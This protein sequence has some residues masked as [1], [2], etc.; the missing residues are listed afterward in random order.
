MESLKKIKINRPLLKEIRYTNEYAKHMKD[1]VANKPRTKEEEVRM[2][3]RLNFNN[4]LADLGA[5][6]SSMPL[7]MYKRLGI[8]KLEQIN[9][10]IEMAN[11]TKCTPKGL[12]ENL[13]VKIDKLIFLVDFVILDIVEDIRMPIILGRPLLATAHAKVDIFRK[14]IS[15]EVG[16]EKVIFKKRS[17]FDPMIFE[18][19][20]VIQSTTCSKNDD[21][22]KMDYDLFLYE[23]ES[24]EFNH[25]LAI[26]PDLFTYDIEVQNSY[27]ELVYT[28]TEQEDPWKIKK[29]D[30]A[31]LESHQDLTPVEKPTVHWCRA[32]SQGKEYECEYWASYNPYSNVCDGGDLPKDD[33]KR[34]WE[35][36]NDS[37]RGELEWEGLSLNDLM[38]IRYRKVCK[39]TRERI[40]KDHWKKRF[41][42][43]ENDIKENSEDLEKYEDDLEGILDYLEPSSYDG[44]IDLDNEAYNERRC[45]LSKELEFEVSSARCHV[46]NR[47]NEVAQLT[48]CKNLILIRS[49][50]QHLGES[51]WVLEDFTTYCCWF[52]IGAASE[53]LV[54]L[55]KIEENRLMFNQC[56]IIVALDLSKVTNPLQAKGSRSIHKMVEEDYLPSDLNNNEI[57]SSRR[58]DRI[59]E[60]RVKEKSEIVKIRENMKG[61]N[62]EISK[63]RQAPVRVQSSPPAPKAAKQLM[64]NEI[65]QRVKSFLLLAIPDEYLLKCSMKECDSFFAH[66]TNHGPP[67]DNEDLQQINQ[68]DL[69]EL[70]IRWKGHFAMECKSGRNQGKRSYG[71]NGRRNMNNK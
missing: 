25:L 53:D 62:I 64:P 14:S 41:H 19:V 16:N 15:L 48:I 43:E 49:G 70:D 66:Q 6:I 8:G 5:S 28:M 9:M 35:S 20:S 33:K 29:M 63:K 59:G 50:E 10:M 30:E 12:V 27:E 44:F 69:E 54:L 57:L 11:N 36:I 40:L 55:R 7:S 32:I 26:D 51:C 31:N 22:K 38:K 60:S 56:F 68:D 71:D 1:L 46:V 42:E 65:R 47:R 37:K 21:L 67:L 17:S 23:T 34:Y 4:A 45:S 3:P 13:L 24:C 52:N 39:M 2:N 61:G 58:E 18:S